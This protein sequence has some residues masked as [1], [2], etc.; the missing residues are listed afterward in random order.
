M[1]DYQKMYTKLFNKVTDVIS[2]LQQWQ[3]DVEQMYIENGDAALLVL[4]AED[5]NSNNNKSITQGES[6]EDDWS[7]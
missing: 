1:P 5:Y 4:K 6:N 3:R 7:S 2:E